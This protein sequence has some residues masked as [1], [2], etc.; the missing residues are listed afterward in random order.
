MGF[1]KTDVKLYCIIYTCNYNNKV[2]D[3]LFVAKRKDA[4]KVLEVFSLY[5][6]ERVKPRPRTLRYVAKVL[7]SQG[8]AVPFE[9]PSA[10]EVSLPTVLY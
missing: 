8:V 10:E 9:V 7:Q 3:F 2:Y 4:K 1:L 5:E 6:E